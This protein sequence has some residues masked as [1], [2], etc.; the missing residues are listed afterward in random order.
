MPRKLPKFLDADEKQKLVSVFNT[1]YDSGLKNLCMVRVMLEAG[2]RVSELCALRVRDLNMATC[3]L[4]VRDGK[5]GK[6]R[7]LWVSHELRDLVGEW[8]ER[9]PKGEWLFPTRT[10]SQT[11]ARSVRRTVKHY[12]EKAGIE[13]FEDVSPH[14]LRHTFAT[15]LLRRTG[16]LRLVQKALGHSDIS[17]TQIYTHVVDE[18]LEQAMKRLGTEIVGQDL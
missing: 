10:G 6:D 11:S 16:N 17:T 3:Q 8:L 12:A 2:L 18:E 14:T 5:G 1:R 4:D 13:W 7:T 9:R 15:E